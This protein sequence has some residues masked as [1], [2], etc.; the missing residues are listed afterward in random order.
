MKKPPGGGGIHPGVGKVAGHSGVPLQEAGAATQSGLF[1]DSTGSCSPVS[2]HDGLQVV[3]E[4]AGRSTDAS[5][6]RARS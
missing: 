3:C 2:E 4:R 1:A 6:L 5:V